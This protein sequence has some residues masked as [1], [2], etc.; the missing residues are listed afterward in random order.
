MV[1]IFVNNF[2]LLMMDMVSLLMLCSCCP[3]FIFLTS[4]FIQHN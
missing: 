1:I 3:A 2:I 4:V